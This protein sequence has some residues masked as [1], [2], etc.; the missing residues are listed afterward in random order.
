MT[1]VCFS[2]IERFQSRTYMMAT[3]EE[4]SVASRVNEALSR[5]CAIKGTDSHGGSYDSIDEMWLAQGVLSTGP[6]EHWYERAAEYYEDNC[7]ANE[8]GVLGGFSSISGI[9]LIGSKRFLEAL[10][11]ERPT[12]DWDG[13]VGCECGAGIGRVSKGLLC[14]LGL[15]RC[16]LI[17]S[18]PRL[19]GEAPDYIGAPYADLCRYFCTGLQQ[20]QPKQDTYS[21]IW[22]QWV[23]CY[24]TDS[25][26]VS[27]LNRCGKSLTE[28]GIIVLKENTCQDET[29]VVD[30][31]DASVTRS[32]PYWLKLVEEAGLSVVKQ[33][34]QTDFPDE[35]FEV[36]ILAL[37]NNK[38]TKSNPSND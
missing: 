1:Q 6:N 30:N 8:D 24:L 10:K 13:A 25:D 17:E 2:R 5:A 9:D 34:L 29:F 23:L 18:S 7:D 16:D 14:P 12:L 4:Q 19:L 31:D 33:E 26:I 27:F 38:E 21:I 11:R 35:I 15:K 32:L 3:G 20:W 36:P 22:V 28:A 37:E